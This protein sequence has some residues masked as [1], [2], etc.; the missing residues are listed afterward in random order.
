MRLN[1]PLKIIKA[2]LLALLIENYEDE[3]HAIESPDPIVEVRKRMD[4]MQLKQKY[5]IGIVGSK[6]I[7]SEVLN[8]KI[9]KDE[10]F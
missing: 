1:Q 3:H 8:K 2:E 5:L 6:R 9:S 7:V 4:E 10:T